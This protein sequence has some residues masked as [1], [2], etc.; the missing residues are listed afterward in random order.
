M[1]KASV[2]KRL[3]INSGQRQKE[4]HYWGRKEVDDVKMRG[5]E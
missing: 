4:V 3:R 2:G 1:G 5:S